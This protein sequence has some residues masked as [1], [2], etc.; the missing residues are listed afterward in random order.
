MIV[1]PKTLIREIARRRVVLFLGAGVSASAK[2]EKGNSPPT[3]GTFLAEANNLIAN[4]A[5]KDDINAY[6]STSR[7]LTA[8]EAISQ[9]VNRAD[10]NQ[11]LD[12]HFNN[13]KFKA[14]PLH[15]KILELD[16]SVVITTNFDKIYEIYCEST[17][18]EGYKVASYDSSDLGD[19]IRSDCRL[20]LK[21]HGSI[22]NITGMI[23]TRSQYHDAKRNHPNF[24]SLLKAIFLTKTCVFIGCSMEDPDIL[25]TL[26]DVK[27][28]ASSN[29]PHYAIMKSPVNKYSKAEWL[30][31]YN[32]DVL[33]YGPDHSQ[34]IDELSNLVAEVDLFRDTNRD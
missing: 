32:I 31:A 6:I 33:E 5:T 22:N 17:S 18:D 26:E 4:P 8:L 16:A 23:F 25:L 3:W 2:D 20:I 10:Y 28:T 14:G 30:N 34:L 24:Y 13:A 15:E 11:L 7:Y 19:L 1:W 27:I 12:R 29:L 21:A 9:E